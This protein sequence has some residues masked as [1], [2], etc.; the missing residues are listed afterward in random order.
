MA[1]ER[2]AGPAPGGGSH[3]VALTDADRDGQAQFAEWA[4][5]AGLALTRDRI[6]NLF[7]EY[8]LTDQLMILRGG[9]EPLDGSELRVMSRIRGLPLRPTAV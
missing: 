2:E 1:T 8:D 4:E 7:A 9:V 5:A 3:R 6:G